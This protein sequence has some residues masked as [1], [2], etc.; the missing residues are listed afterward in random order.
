[1]IAPSRNGAREVGNL[2][3]PFQSREKVTLIVQTY[4]DVSLATQSKT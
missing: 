1:M 3:H 4:L 2:I